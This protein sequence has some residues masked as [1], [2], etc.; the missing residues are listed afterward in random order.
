MKADLGR[1]NQRREALLAQPE[2]IDEILADGAR[3]ARAVARETMAKVYERLG[4]GV[5]HAP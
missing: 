3:R 5:G 1:I 2:Q 4:L